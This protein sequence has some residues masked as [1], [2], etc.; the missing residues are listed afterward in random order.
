MMVVAARREEQR[1]RIVPHG[2]FEAQGA[3]VEAVCLGEVGHLEVDVAQPGVRR[4]A[5]GT[6]RDRLRLACQRVEVQRQRRHPHPSVGVPPLAR[7]ITVDL[8]AV[9][10]RVAE[11]ERLADQVVGRAAQPPPGADQA[12]QGPGQVEAAGHEDREV[13]QPGAPRRPPRSVRTARQLD[14]RRAI[15]AESHGVAVTAKLTQAERPLVEAAGRREVGHDEAHRPQRGS[16][17]D[18]VAWGTVAP[19]GSARPL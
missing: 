6:G 10:L 5:V 19:A 18:V 1:P 9:S 16:R 7:A 8:D 3:A 15:H 13:E 14:Q 17:V 2:H 11:V 4:H 12:V